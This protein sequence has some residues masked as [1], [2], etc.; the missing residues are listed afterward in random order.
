MANRNY[1][2]V[3]NNPTHTPEALIE[4][5]FSSNTDFKYAV[6]QKEKGEN[7]TVHYQ[8]YMELKT[9]R[10]V[11]W[12][13]K[14]MPTAHFEKRRGTREQARD[15]CCKEDSKVDGPWEYGEFGQQRGKRTDLDA[16]YKAARSKATLLEVAEEAPSAY[17]RYYKAVQHVRQIEAFSKPTRTEDNKL[18][19][20]LL[21]GSPGTG[22]TR[23]AYEEAPDLYAIPVGKQLWADN[24]AGEPDVLFDDF[25]GNVRL[26][27]ALRMLDRY[28]IQVPIK[29]GFVWWCPRRIYITTN[30]HPRDWYNFDTR[31][32]QYRALTRR[33][34]KVIQFHEDGERQTFDGDARANFF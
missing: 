29:G 30:K 12:L 4:E 28:P 7:G 13:K 9:P 20:I 5:V 17:M 11:A 26:V 8:G 22:K 24:Y 23:M 25:T 19:V 15:Y 33:I 1:I 27:D 34:T 31:A 18:E 6:F 16:L 14:L 3:I 10:R 21:Y 32:D 2:F